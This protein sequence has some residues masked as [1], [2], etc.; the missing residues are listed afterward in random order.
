MGR[1]G[2]NTGCKWGNLREG[3]HLENPSIDGRIILKCMLESEM[4]E[5]RLD[6]SGTGGGALVNAVVNLRFS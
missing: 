5:R 4:G 1:E 3:D 2:V 6:R